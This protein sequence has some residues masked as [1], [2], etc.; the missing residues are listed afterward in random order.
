MWWIMMVAM[1]LP[2][3]AS[4]ILLYARVAQH[5]DDAG[6]MATG[7]FLGGYLAAWG[8]FSAL[9][10]LL[11]H[12]LERAGYLAG[13]AMASQDRAFSAAVL[14]AVGLY[15]LSPLKDAC[16]HRCQ[17]P[18]QFLSRHWRAG[19]FGAMRLGLLHG[20]FC[21]GCCWMLMALLLVGGIMNL[22]WI[23]ALTAIVAAEKL[24]P[25]GRWVAV[26]SG[27]GCLAWG[28]GLAMA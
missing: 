1:M 8:L 9:A 5:S 24:L 2:S 10:T 16:L 17:S 27:L 14:I 20:A 22:A 26:V 6:R 13:G 15:Q 23:A 25:W 18:A 12:G 28:V 21:V 11:Q 19:A 7:Y 4:A 3:A